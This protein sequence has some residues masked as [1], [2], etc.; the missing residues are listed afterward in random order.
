MTASDHISVD[1]PLTVCLLTSSGRGAVASLGLVG[2]L[3]I[4]DAAFAAVNGVPAAQQELDRICYGRWGDVPSEDVVWIRTGPRTA[5]LHCHGGIA[6][7]ERI[8]HEIRRRGGNVVDPDQWL[9][10]TAPAAE[11]ECRWALARTTTRR[12]A[13]HVL[14][15]CRLFPEA[16]KSLLPLAPVARLALLDS[17][18]AWSRFGLHLA[19]P[20]RVVLCG[21]PNVGKSSLIN[22]LLG[23][24]RS[25]VF[26][27]PGTTRD[28]VT[29]ETALQGWPVEF[30]DTAG[31]RE[32]DAEL[33][34][35]G[36]QRA[37]RQLNAADLV[38]IVLDA[39]AGLLDEDVQLLDEFPAALVVWNKADLKT[40]EQG[41]H[42]SA[43]TGE[44][45][46]ELLERIARL[47]VPEEPP[48][49]T[50]FPVTSVQLES[51]ARLRAAAACSDDDFQRELLS[52]R[53]IAGPSG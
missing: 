7:V 26:D 2:D 3:S 53:S 28:I 42:V 23:Y 33:E 51:L 6:A 49:A 29:G 25:I 24:T 44:G 27:Q 43:R 48:A 9:R 35:Q 19:Q 5:E 34:S 11:A 32:T 41:L 38:V 22:A 47:L 10:R 45:I 40:R 18:L 16:L 21:R 13:H 14:R 46:E 17:M 36:I 8:L 15:Q 4:L 12:A 39:A 52:L 30:S 50:A 20:W 31:L 1:S 37:R